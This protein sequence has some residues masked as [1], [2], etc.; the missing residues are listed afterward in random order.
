V[1]KTFIACAVVAVLLPLSTSVQASLVQGNRMASRYDLRRFTRNQL[2]WGDQN[3]DITDE[4]G[5]DIPYSKDTP[6]EGAFAQ[7]IWVGPDGV[8]DD[9]VYDGN[10]TSG[11]DEVVAITYSYN[12]NL[13]AKTNRFAYK[14]VDNA[15]IGGPQNGSNY[16]VRVFNGANPNYA[17]VDTAITGVT[18][19]TYYYQSDTHAF[20]WRGETDPNPDYF[21][22]TGGSDQQTTVMAVPEPSSMLLLAVGGLTA[23]G[24]KRRK[25]S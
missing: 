5:D 23:A 1:K 12:S 25:R 13:S 11:D 24:L 16:Y 8:P 15:I 10:G 21:Y 18:D 4:V 6:T 14:P 7:L 17:D 9:F 22:I 20:D 3:N 19:I 2:R